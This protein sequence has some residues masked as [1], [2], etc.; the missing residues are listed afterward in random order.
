M[1]FQMP[2]LKSRWKVQFRLPREE[3]KPAQRFLK[4]EVVLSV[5][6]LTKAALVWASTTAEQSSWTIQQPLLIWLIA[7]GTS[8]LK[9]SSEKA[10]RRKKEKSKPSKWKT[11]PSGKS[12]KS[13]SL[14]RGTTKRKRRSE[15]KNS[16]NR[17]DASQVTSTTSMRTR[18]SPICKLSKETQ[19]RWPSTSGRSIMPCSSKRERR[20]SKITKLEI[21]NSRNSV[22]KM[23]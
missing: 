22:K 3:V 16:T 4:Q 8:K 6:G 23:L 15:T 5:E 11:L 17:S 20:L 2:S 1:I 13:R 21:F 19:A 18:R 7:D 12:S 9:T 14:E 10:K